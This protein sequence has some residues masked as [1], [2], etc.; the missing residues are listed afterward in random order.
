M[1]GESNLDDPAQARM[2]MSIHAQSGGATVGP[3][4]ARS[5]H[6]AL[7][8]STSF[9]DLLEWCRI[10]GRPY[11]KRAA[12]TAV[13]YVC[14]QIEATVD[15]TYVAYQENREQFHAVLQQSDREKSSS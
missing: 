5:R 9:F 6:H 12:E 3:T 11:G 14:L 13:V 7:S 10:A 1:A 15:T 2:H 8:D 4:G